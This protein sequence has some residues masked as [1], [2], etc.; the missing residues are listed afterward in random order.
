MAEN[1]LGFNTLR[2]GTISFVLIL[3]CLA[4]QPPSRAQEQPDIF[5]RPGPNPAQ[6][7]PDLSRRPPVINP[8]AQVM[9][10]KA[11]QA[12]GGASFLSFKRLTTKGRAFAIS[13]ESTAGLSPFESAVE[14]PD[15]RRASYG[16]KPPVIL[17]N[18]GKQGWEIDRYGVMSQKREDLRD[19]Q[20]VN[21]YSLEN[22]LRLRIHEPGMLVQEG[23]A[24]FVDE[25]P[26][27]IVTMVDAQQTEIKLYLH[28]STFLPVRITYHTW[29]AVT[30]DWDDRADV[31]GDYQKI[32]GIESP[33]H[34]TR[35]LNDERVAEIY[36]NSAKYDETYPAGYFEAPKR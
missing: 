12:L 29:N 1:R 34:I 6:N 28:S 16:K 4:G 20:L 14:Y 10:D 26:V 30:K 5:K 17:I 25:A 22:L 8:K 23:G 24:D 9:L 19:W 15:K 36:R 13:D 21:R 31:Y 32:Q 27:R 35:F 3:L 11:I 7:H 33:M 18:N 2:R